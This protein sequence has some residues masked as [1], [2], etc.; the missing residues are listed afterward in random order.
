MALNVGVIQVRAAEGV[1]RERVTAAIRDHW[2]GCVA[3]DPVSL[4]GEFEPMALQAGKSD[5]LAFAVSPVARGWVTV[6]DSEA[7][8]AD[9]ALAQHLHELLGVEVVWYCLTGNADVAAVRVYGET[10]LE[11]PG[12]EVDDAGDYAEVERWAKATFENALPV[13]GKDTQLWQLFGFAKVDADLYVDDPTWLDAEAVEA[14]A[15]Q[16]HAKPGV[17]QE[18][19][20]EEV[21]RYWEQAG[22]QVSN[23]V[24]L[25]ESPCGIISEEA[26]RLV[27]A[28]GPNVEGWITIVDSE[29]EVAD[30][31]LADWLAAELDTDVAWYWVDSS[32]EMG[33]IRLFGFEHLEGEP[34]DDPDSVVGFA[35]ETFPIPFSPI[36]LVDTTWT[37]LGFTS[38][39]PGEY[40][41]DP[42][43]LD[44]AQDSAAPDSEEN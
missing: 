21:R 41:T 38:V 20:V 43:W 4:A 39:S 9:A 35:Q 33:V 24:T 14:G 27:V 32:S 37:K 5:R 30:L 42:S 16:V 26:D 31:G 1:D 6:V 11:L 44:Q 3:L 7:Y 18:R 28:V 36:D 34:P 8:T 2:A 23:D 12:D 13:Y 10:E 25:P 19:V 29:R 22:A 40:V 15:I 17:D